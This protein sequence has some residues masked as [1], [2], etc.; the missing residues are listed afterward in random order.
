MPANRTPGRWPYR[1]GGNTR[2]KRVVRVQKDDSRG[3]VRREPPQPPQLTRRQVRGALA[4]SLIFAVVAGAWWAWHSPYLTV[5]NIEVRGATL[6]DPKTIS[7]AAALDGDSAFRVDID[8]AE[9]R[10][11]ALP[12]V[13]DAEITREGWTGV[14]ISINERTPW[15]SWQ[16]N[17]VNVPIDD[18]GYVLSTPAPEGSPVILEVEPQRALS[19]GDRIDPG[20]VQLAGRLVEESD[21]AFGRTVRALIYRQSAGL[22][23]VLSGADIEGKPLWVT[24]GD[25]RDYDFKVAALYVLLEQAKADDLALSAVD[26]RFGDRLSFN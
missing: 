14:T 16:I 10:V 19:A 6:L 21:T 12:Q 24:F 11:E 1:A 20:A 2:S 22:T 3:V 9:A 8:A 7:D 25:D 15:G 23:V 4:A 18:E 13:R 26:L 17:G 5:S